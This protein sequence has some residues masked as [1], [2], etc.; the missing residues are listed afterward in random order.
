MNI[1][2]LDSLFLG[3]FLILL[4]EP[5]I[6]LFASCESSG[7]PFQIAQISQEDLEKTEKELKNILKES[8][9]NSVANTGINTGANTG[10]GESGTSTNTDESNANPTISSTP[11]TISTDDPVSHSPSTSTSK[12]TST[13]T[14]NKSDSPD[15][16]NSSDSAA[17]PDDTK[18]P[19][20]PVSIR[21]CEGHMKLAKRRF[22]EGSLTGAKDELDIVFE[23]LPNF[24]PARFMKAVICAKTKDFIGAWRSINI[25]QREAPNNPKIKAFIDKLEKVSPK[26]S[27]IPD[28]VKERQQAQ[29]ASAMFYDTFEKLFSDKSLGPKIIRI[30]G[31]EPKESGG[32]IAFKISLQSQSDLDKASIEKIFKG[33]DKFSISSSENA[34]GGKEIHLEIAVAGVPRQNPSMAV[35]SESSSFIEEIRK[36]CD[37]KINDSTEGNTDPQGLFV[38]TY[39]L[40]AADFP[41]VNDFLR[42]TSKKSAEYWITNLESTTFNQKPIWKGEVKVKFKSQ[43]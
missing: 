35:I 24:A 30:K 19:I 21:F 2:R 42:A 34:S 27:V 16:P 28:E 32:K 10:S 23:R 37:V 4:F 3:F 36:D 18:A 6:L 9:T 7:A 29:F 1:R 22:K 11:I 5:S 8:S 25:A 40:M 33:N 41:K 14:S 20:D 38:G 17:G 15:K 13:A 31:D 39:Q 26:P 43:K 12:S